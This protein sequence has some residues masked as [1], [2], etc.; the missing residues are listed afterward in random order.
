MPIGDVIFLL[1]IGVCIGGVA[2]L[3]FRSKRRN[4][5]VQSP[6]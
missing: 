1:F 5:Q 3:A 4:A 2:V 6:E